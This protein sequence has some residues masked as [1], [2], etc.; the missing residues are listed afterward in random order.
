MSIPSFALIVTAAGSSLRFS[1]TYE[2]S[3]SVKKEFLQLDGHSVLYRATEPFFEIPSLQA[4]VVTYKDDSLD[5]TIVA[6]EDLAD[7]NTI[8]MFFVKGGKS[9]RESVKNALDKLKEINIPFEYVAIQ[10]GARP[11][12]TPRLIINVLATAFNSS[13]AVP[14]LPVTDS[15][16]RIDK[17]GSIIECPSRSGLVRVQTPQFFEFD[18]LIAAYENQDINKATDDSEIYVKAGCNCCVCEGDE[19]NIKITYERDIPDAR[20]QIESYIEDRRKGRASREANETFRR[21]LNQVED[22]L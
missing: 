13:G 8:P 3:E 17:T 6:L 4:V 14:A 5:E 7:I 10:D 20:K 1:S 19:A 11:Y 22:E 16:R 18:K 9:R 12:V 21:L 2:N 15:I